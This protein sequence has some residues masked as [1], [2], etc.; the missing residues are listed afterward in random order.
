MPILGDGESPLPDGRLAARAESPKGERPSE[1]PAR[2]S[3]IEGRDRLREKDASDAVPSYLEL[4]ALTRD[5]DDEPDRLVLI[6]GGGA[7]SRP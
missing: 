7:R 2:D 5:D 4:C 6:A 3:S 1:D